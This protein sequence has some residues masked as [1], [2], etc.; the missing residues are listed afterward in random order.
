MNDL[1]STPP[2][3]EIVSHSANNFDFLR[4][5]FATVVIFSHCFVLC[6][7]GAGEPLVRLS[8]GQAYLA[9]LAVNGFFAISG[10]LITASWMRRP[11]WGDYLKKRV[12]RIYPGFLVTGIV[13]AFL[14]GAAGSISPAAYLHQIQPGRFLFH[15]LLLD[16]LA[17]PPTFSHNSV[18]DQVNGSLWTI[19]IEFEFY[20]M[21]AVLGTLRLFQKR[22][23]PLVLTVC[24]LLLYVLLHIHRVPTHL[25][26]TFT[27]HLRFLSYFLTGMVF[28]L[29]RDKVSYSW[30]WAACAVSILA[31]GTWTHTLEA[32]L[33]LPLVYLLMAAAFSP[34][35]GLHQFGR[36]RDISY[37][38]YLYAWPIQQLL[39][40]H[41]DG[42]RHPW[43][44]FLVALPLTAL[45]A[46]LSWHLIEKPCLRLKPKSNRR[47]GSASSLSRKP[48]SSEEMAAEGAGATVSST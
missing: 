12:L 6:G 32:V 16:K 42:M 40:Q 23:L 2:V 48:Q 21:V 45:A 33:P 18:T 14:V 13:C 1:S 35:V 4:F 46:V 20:L 36:R 47:A 26:E 44:L 19:K 17:V 15:Q 5:L 30:A 11:Q 39:V 8:G 31:F 28:F 29:Y 43:G 37:G 3:P 7:L 34:G 24:C 10:F 25:P 41:F 38:L 22:V 27:E 9:E